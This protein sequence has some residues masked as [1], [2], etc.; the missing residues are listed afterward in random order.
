MFFKFHILVFVT[1][2][3]CV[4]G[5]LPET[6]DI[7]ESIIIQFHP[8][9]TVERFLT[10]YPS[11]RFKMAGDVTIG[12]FKAIFGKFDRRFVQMLSHSTLVCSHVK[13]KKM[14]RSKYTNFVS[15][16]S[17]FLEIL[18]FVLRMYKA[19]L[20]DTFLESLDMSA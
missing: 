13:K 6:T 12:S 1:L 10:T 17:I 3:C 5:S 11:L 15:R 9:L 8:E 20:L 14:L 4:Y 18:M 19:K 16:F 7:N 2:F